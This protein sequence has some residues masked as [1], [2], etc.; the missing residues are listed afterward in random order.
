MIPMEQRASGS[1]IS[2]AERRALATFRR[3][4]GLMRTAAAIAA[5][6][7]PWTLY[8]LRDAG[9]IEQ[10][11]RGLY[12]ITTAE[13]M[14]APDIA[15]VAAKVPQAVVC[16]I[17][18]L[19]WH[20]LTTQI[21]HHVHVA[22][23]RSAHKP[24]LSYPPVRVYWFADACYSTG[25]EVHEVDGVLVRIYSPEKTLADCFKFRH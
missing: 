18:A 16:L 11:A 21:P 12:R 1:M 8:A 4:G 23:K 17:S 5:G 24:R 7:N 19:D 13:P 3:H 25:I 10:V 15:T 6:V 22:L 9:L 14:R 2:G 20:G